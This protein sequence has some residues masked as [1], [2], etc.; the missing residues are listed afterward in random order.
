MTTDKRF[1]HWSPRSHS[2]QTTLSDLNIALT[3]WHCDPCGLIQTP[4]HSCRSPCQHP[5]LQAAPNLHRPVTWPAGLH[6][7]THS[8]PSTTVSRLRFAH[9]P[10]DSEQRDITQTPFATSCTRLGQSVLLGVS[11]TPAIY[12]PASPSLGGRVRSASPR[13][14][15]C[16][17]HAASVLAPLLKCPRPQ[18]QQKEVP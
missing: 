7:P 1:T 14:S 5:E 18:D 9:I 12:A 6:A 4:H 17:A 8:C 16:G 3:W 15:G 13:T 11:H 2:D 10:L